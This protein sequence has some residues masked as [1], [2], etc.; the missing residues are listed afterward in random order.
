MPNDRKEGVHVL[1]VNETRALAHTGAGK[2]PRMSSF[3][4]G[5]Y[6]TKSTGRDIPG[7]VTRGCDSVTRG[8]CDCDTK[9]GVAHT[10]V[11]FVQTSD[12]GFIPM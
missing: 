7:G 12:I 1:L 4:K 5:G 2:L 8:L 3:S 10:K 6:V 9:T 11:V